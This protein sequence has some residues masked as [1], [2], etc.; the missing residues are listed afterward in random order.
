MLCYLVVIAYVMRAACGCILACVCVAYP[1]R[2]N[3]TH[4]CIRLSGSISLGI[5]AKFS[6]EISF[7]GYITGELSRAPIYSGVP[8]RIDR[9]CVIC[10]CEGVRFA[11]QPNGRNRRVSYLLHVSAAELVCRKGRRR[12]A[13]AV[14]HAKLHG[15]RRSV[16]F[17]PTDPWLFPACSR[18]SR[19]NARLERPRW[20]KYRSTRILERNSE[21]NSSQCSIL[22]SQCL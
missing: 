7:T 12:R 15:K 17:T 19:I 6:G 11:E 1:N 21:N 20:W 3:T 22:I 9:Q 8:P 10:K 16:G 2:E 13:N 18:I 4:G 5:F 14:H